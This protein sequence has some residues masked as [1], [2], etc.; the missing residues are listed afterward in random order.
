MYSRA[1]TLAVSALLL[2]TS[3]WLSGK[4]VQKKLRQGDPAVVDTAD[5]GEAD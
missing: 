4:E 2:L 3:C 5:T 1:T